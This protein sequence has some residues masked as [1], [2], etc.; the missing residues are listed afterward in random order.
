MLVSVSARGKVPAKR[1]QDLGGSNGMLGD[2]AAPSL[3]LF[4]DSGAGAALAAGLP[5]ATWNGKRITLRCA[6]D[7]LRATFCRF[8]GHVGVVDPTDCFGLS[9]HVGGN[10]GLTLTAS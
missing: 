8:P 1:L 7:R 3:G 10:V 9:I 2:S 5:S 6:L 4:W